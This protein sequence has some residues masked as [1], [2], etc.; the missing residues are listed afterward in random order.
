VAGLWGVDV[1]IALSPSAAPRCGR[2]AIPPE[3]D[4][5]DSH[6]ES[7]VK[8]ANSI[9]V[10]QVKSIYTDSYGRQWVLAALQHRFAV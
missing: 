7:R 3:G 9:E 5:A 4:S 6:G 8:A 1:C 2:S 10:Q